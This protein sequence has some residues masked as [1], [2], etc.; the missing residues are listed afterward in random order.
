MANSTRGLCL[1]DTW[2]HRRLILL[3]V[4]GL[5]SLCPGSG[6]VPPAEAQSVS[7]TIPF[8]SA[9]D[10]REQIQRV[11]WRR[12]NNLFAMGG[13]SLIAAQ[14]RGA[15]TLSLNLVTRS[16][17][18]RLSG[19]LRAGYLGEYTP[20]VDEP[21]D[22]IRLVEFARY[23][24]PRNHR[25]HLRAGL[26]DRISLGVGH[27]VSFFN[28]SIAWDERTVG[29]EFI[30]Q[31]R[32][33]ELAGFTD[34]VLFDGV[35]GGRVALRP[36]A[37]SRLRYTRT[38]QI[39]FNY[40]TDRTSRLPDTRR[41]EAYN[42][43]LQ[44][45]LFESGS[46]KFAPYASY[47]WYPG[48]GDGIAFGGDLYSERFIDLLSFRLRVGLFYNSQGFIP[49]YIGAFYP[50]NNPQARI[51]DSDADLGNIQE[52][53]LKGIALQQS[54]GANDLLTELKIQLG[55]FELWYYFR[56][57]YGH[58]RLSELH[59]RLFLRTAERIRLEVGIDR[60][61]LKGF[62]TLFND[63]GDQSALVF[64]TDYYLVG[65]LWLFLRARYSFERVQGD[66]DH[67]QRFLVQR[68]F[69]PMTGI[70]LRF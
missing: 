46:V 28:S 66:M 62:F 17:T 32:I 11:W 69:E 60:Q 50:V 15:G 38:A 39:G 18:G 55:G 61:G 56:R 64:G 16:I 3:L 23:N 36:L 9:D 8:G 52:T 43:D 65:P 12:E 1:P 30:R 27:T 44:F 54:A 5:W 48:F 59:L 37:W 68:R 2:V 29:A 13:L 10:P 21:Y 22:L 6:S 63:L 70:R 24:P 45:D 42:I 49:G 47:A 7:Q 53:D 26:L 51:V 67:A 19:T 34:N 58:Q 25:V 57:H 4:A 35:V 20:D 31:G 33:L 40:A 41:L 14:W